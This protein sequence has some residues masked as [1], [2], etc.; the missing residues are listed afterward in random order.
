MAA[1]NVAAARSATDHGAY[2]ALF[3]NMLGHAL[4][5]LLDTHHHE[6]QHSQS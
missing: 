4:I 2:K 1:A 6:V 5:E 3:V